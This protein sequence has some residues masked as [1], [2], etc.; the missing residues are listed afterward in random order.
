M[1]NEYNLVV[2]LLLVLLIILSYVFLR[3]TNSSRDTSLRKITRR[4]IGLVVLSTSTL[5]MVLW[6]ITSSL[7]ETSGFY[8]PK[9]GL[10]LACIAIIFEAI[11]VGLV[12]LAPWPKRLWIR[13]IIGI[14][15]LLFWFFYY[16]VL[17]AAPYHLPSPTYTSVHF[18]W[19]GLLILIVG[20]KT[21]DS[22]ISDVLSL[23][24]G[25]LGKMRKDA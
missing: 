1:S 13:G 2:G 22:F 14:A 3:D 6:S 4:K 16:L 7:D 23:I 10:F 19:S 8:Q 15:I 24:R 21:I 18:L 20:S 17:T 9:G 25:V 12:T 5:L 11:V